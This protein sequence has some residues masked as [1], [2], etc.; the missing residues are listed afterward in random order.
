MLDAK[1]Y[2]VLFLIFYILYKKKLLYFALLWTAS[3]GAFLDL[4]LCQFTLFCRICFWN[5]GNTHFSVRYWQHMYL[6]HAFIIRCT[7]IDEY[8]KTILYTWSAFVNSFCVCRCFFIVL[9][10]FHFWFNLFVTIC[11]GFAKCTFYG[12]IVNMKGCLRANT[13]FEDCIN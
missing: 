11:H 6:A 7:L 10:L 3:H 2:C 5:K 13:L 1:L 9:L 12:I 4:F 8:Q